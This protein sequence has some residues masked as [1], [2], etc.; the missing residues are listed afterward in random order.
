METSAPN[1]DPESSSP[2]DDLTNLPVTPT[3]SPSI[4]FTDTARFAPSS[5]G[6]KVPRIPP[7]AE[8]MFMGFS[9]V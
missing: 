6:V 8:L 1:A 2:I 4:T 3:E 9:M 7:A 5:E